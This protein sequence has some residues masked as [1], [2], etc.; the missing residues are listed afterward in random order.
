MSHR[1]TSLQFLIAA[2]VLSTVC[3]QAFAS[4]YDPGYEQQPESK[5]LPVSQLAPLLG[6]AELASKSGA[7]R[8]AKPRSYLVVLKDH[9]TPEA[10]RAAVLDAVMEQAL[11]KGA[12]ISQRYDVLMHGF[13]GRLDAHTLLWLRSHPEVAYVEVDAAVVQHGSQATGG[14]LWHL[15]RIDQKTRPLDG[16]YRFPNDGAGAHVYVLDSGIRGTHAEFR[17]ASGGSRVVSLHN[18]VNPGQPTFES[19]ASHGTQVAAM[20]GGNT[21]GTAKNARIYDVRVFPCGGQ[22]TVSVVLAGLQEAVRDIQQNQRRPAII[23]ASLGLCRDPDPA[24]PCK[25]HGDQ[26]SLTRGFLRA[27]NQGIMVITA[28]GN[29]GNLQWLGRE[30]VDISPGHLG[31][32]TSVLNVGSVDNADRRAESSSIGH[33]VNLMAPGVQVRTAFTLSDSSYTNVSGTSFAAPL[34][35]GA[36]AMCLTQHPD[37]STAELKRRLVNCGSQ[38]ALQANSL[39]GS[40]NVLL[41]VNACGCTSGPTLTDLPTSHWA[42][43]NV[44]CLERFGVG[45]R[46]S[47]DRFAPDQAMQRWEMAVY[48]VQA[49][50]EERNI[51]GTYQSSFDDV[52][53]NAWWTPHVEHFRTLGVTAGCGNRRYCPQDP[54]KRWQMAVFLVNSLGA[55]TSTTHRGYFVDVGQSHPHRAA[56]ERLFEL[57][58]TSGEMVNGVRY[59][60]PDSNTT[61]AQITAFVAAA[62]RVRTGVSKPFPRSLSCS[63]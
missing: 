49:M 22:S 37:L 52:P 43:S 11:R 58:V 8:S 19:C 38:G 32:G 16:W 4:D 29:M 17:T 57:G 63:G 48:L 27:A 55:T 25:N 60:R 59:F 56:I 62:S 46:A 61:R 51:S 1:S 33:A 10:S 20:A 13:A 5:Q 31:A 15:D 39:G 53:V 18:A 3:S 34:V 24:A 9:S 47:A 26:P 7:D 21:V 50:G 30:A 44:A 45:F 54:V 2:T 35:A 41:D 36:A 6:E 23:N 28:A 42:Y 14:N 12:E 40:P